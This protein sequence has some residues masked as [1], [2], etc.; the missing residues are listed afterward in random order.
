MFDDPD[1]GRAVARFFGL[2]MRETGG[3]DPAVVVV[4]GVAPA[5]DHIRS[6]DGRL[7]MGALLAMA[8]SVAGLCGGLAALPGWVVSTNLML[9][10]VRLDVVGPIDLVAGVRRAGRNAVVTSISVTDAG[11]GGRPVADG[12]LT[13]AILVPEGGPPTHTRPLVIA[14]PAV[15]PAAMPPLDEFL[16]ARPAGPDALALDITEP[17]RNPWGILHG[18]VTAGLVDLAC[19][20]ATG[21]TATTD[22]VVHFLSPGR[23]GPVVAT[24]ARH[25]T[26]ADGHL[27][28]TEIRD[29][30]ADARLMAVAIAT[31]RT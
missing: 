25:G 12:T 2:T 11:A 28:R 27:V 14:A 22:V 13:S 7:A 19:R 18:G 1:A 16:G 15:D 3:T 6:P 29:V 24:V 23:V 21:G 30:G 5:A 26:R 10:A 17:L 4:T 20:H 9:R 8:D 31:V